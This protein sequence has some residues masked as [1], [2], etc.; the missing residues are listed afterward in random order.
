VASI[1]GDG[2]IETGETCDG[3]SVQCTALSPDY[4][5]GTA[6]CNSTCSGYNT[7]SCEE[8]GW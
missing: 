2:I 5:G 8:D 3:N 7:G 6:T 1:C 4:I